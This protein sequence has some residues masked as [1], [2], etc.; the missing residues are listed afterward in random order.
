VLFAEHER[1]PI[2]SA[3][4]RNVRLEDDRAVSNVDDRECMRVAVRV[5]A[6]DVVQLI[7]EHP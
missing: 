6:N 5:D 2:A 3:V 7:C 1:S 4:C